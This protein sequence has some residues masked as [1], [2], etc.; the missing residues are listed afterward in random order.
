MNI[1]C[2]DME[3]VLVPEIWIAFAE[4]SSIPELKRTTRDE[5]DY[6]KLMAPGYFKGARP[7][8]EGDPGHHRHHR[9]AARREGIPGRAAAADPSGG[10]Q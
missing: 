5:P 7:G 6:D 8:P 1:V 4:A 9:P 10:P 2:L 3:G